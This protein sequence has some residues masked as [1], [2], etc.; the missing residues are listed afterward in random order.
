MKRKII[1][2]VS[3]A[4]AILLVWGVHAAIRA[5]SKL[6]T[7]DV[8]NA[9]VRDVVRKMEWQTWET[10]F[11]QKGVAGKI[12]L[13]VHKIPL[14]QA[15]GLIDEQVSSRWSVVYPLYSTSK[16]L[17]AFRQSARGE[18]SPA[19][20]GWSNY[21][22][23]PFVPGIG[24]GFGGFGRNLGAQ[25]VP[26]SLR[27]DDQDLDIATLALGRYGQARVVPEDGTSGKVLMT[28]DRVTMSQAVARVARQVHR[29]WT[30]Y[31][32]LQTGGRGGMMANG[33]GQPQDADAARER[34][35]ALLQTLSAEDRQK[36]EEARQRREQFQN[37]TPE[38]RQQAMA[39]RMAD[40]Q[41]Q[42]Q[43]QNR[44]LQGLLNSTPEERVA[45][46]QRRIQRAAQRGG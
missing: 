20:N 23:R 26:I 43:M 9:D 10:I 41:F 28:L 17:A 15:L 12:T 13:N 45:R 22:A 39:Q 16:S 8:R 38:Q 7:L 34:Y 25:D 32:V 14:E 1:F 44:M 4:A 35:D 24:G 27:F 21:L 19:Q 3:T 29:K 31:Y 18:I 11:V 5:H 2:T 37:M 6:V 40:P 33:R 30:K 42:T 36:A 46:N